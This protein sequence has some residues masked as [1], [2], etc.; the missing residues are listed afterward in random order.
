MTCGGDQPQCL[1]FFLQLWFCSYLVQYPEF[2]T[3][4]LT[5]CLD[6]QNTAKAN[7]PNQHNPLSHDHTKKKEKQKEVYPYKSQFTH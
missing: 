6:S 4:R 7:I 1:D 2:L 3:N 5:A